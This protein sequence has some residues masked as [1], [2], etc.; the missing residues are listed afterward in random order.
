[1]IPRNGLSNWLKRLWYVHW[2]WWSKRMATERKFW[3]KKCMPS[4]RIKHHQD[5]SGLVMPDKAKHR[6]DTR[7]EKESLRLFKQ[8]AIPGVSR[9]MFCCL[10]VPFIY[11][12]T[13]HFFHMIVHLSKQQMDQAKTA[14]QSKNGTAAHGAHPNTNLPIHYL[15]PI[16]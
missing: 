3:T 14:S 16:I 4:C 2:F 7:F 1:M 13:Q 6:E 11:S 15:W 12:R 10:S 8:L 9:T 5:Q